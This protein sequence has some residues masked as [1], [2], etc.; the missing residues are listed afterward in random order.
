M[1][2]DVKAILLLTNWP[3][4]QDALEHIDRLQRAATVRPVAQSVA[5]P[6]SHRSVESQPHRPPPGAPTHDEQPVTRGWLGSLA[7]AAGAVLS[8]QRLLPQL[9]GA[10]PRT[11][12]AMPGTASPGQLP[13][14]QTLDGDGLL[15]TVAAAHSLRCP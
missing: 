13:G 12:P 2:C 6:K 5:T 15:D 8:P 14:R 7:A 9:G 11:P 1:R 3:R 4:V 10:L